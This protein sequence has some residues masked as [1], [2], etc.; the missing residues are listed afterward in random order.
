MKNI[1]YF[2][3]KGWNDFFSPIRYELAEDVH[4]A[5]LR[6]YYFIFKEDE[7]IKFHRYLFDEQ[8]VPQVRTH[9]DVGEFRYYYN[10]NF[11]GQYALAVYH[12]YLKKKDEKELERFIRLADWFVENQE[13]RLKD[14]VVWSTPVPVPKFKVESNW[15]SAMYQGR[16]ASVLTRAYL[17]TQDR[18]YLDLA[19][20]AFD[21]FAVDVADG[22]IRDQYS[23]YTFYEEYPSD[24]PCHVL[25]GMVFALFGLQDL[26]RVAATDRLEKLFREGMK[27]I[28]GVVAL[29][30]LGFWTKYDL[31]DITVGQEKLNPATVHYQFL[32]IDQMNVLHKITAD[33]FFGD[34]ARKW[35]GY[36]KVSNRL[37]AYLLK[38]KRLRNVHS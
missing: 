24:P 26:L 16:A 35:E 28:K 17:K 23:G 33:S 1:I 14:Y 5:E 37:K 21:I 19:E 10:P 4:S 27:T 15:I 31:C 7:L 18:K 22:G 2:A 12:N 20:R 36:V 11:V 3:R 9:A 13:T 25:N 30:D 29:F 8:G 34:Y 32:H 38:Y 6:E